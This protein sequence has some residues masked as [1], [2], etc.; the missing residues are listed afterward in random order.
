MPGVRVA[1][2]DDIALGRYSVPSLTT[3]SPD[4]PGPARAA[5]KLL[6]DEIE[7]RRSAPGPPED[8]VAGAGEPVPG[9]AAVKEA[10]IG[11]TLLIRE[12]SGPKG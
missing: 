12:S 4:K 6:T 11:H 10:V 5:V 2:F 3:V 7:A 1:G 8:T 9:E